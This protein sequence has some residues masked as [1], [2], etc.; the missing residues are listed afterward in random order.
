MQASKAALAALDKVNCDVANLPKLTDAELEVIRMSQ[1]QQA[2]MLIAAM[3]AACDGDA[4]KF[5]ALLEDAF[6]ADP[7]RIVRRAERAL[8]KIIAGK[9][10]TLNQFAALL[11]SYQREIEIYNA[12]A[13]RREATA[14]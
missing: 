3:V 12:E 13:E 8:D 6:H 4:E 2:S 11:V 10:P 5:Q 14:Q 1:A 9:R 7:E